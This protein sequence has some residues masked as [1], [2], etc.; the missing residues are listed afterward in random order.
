MNGEEPELRRALEGRS[1]SPSPEFRA[2]LASALGAGRPVA[3]STPRLALAGA[4]ILA[5]AVVG[6][7]LMARQ[8]GG[9]IAP[10]PGSASGPR[11]VATPTPA[12]CTFCPIAMPT[13]A[14]LSAPSDN[15]VW[16]LVQDE[17]LARSTDRGADWERRPLPTWSGQTP[18]LEMSF[19]DDHEG[20]LLAVGDQIGACRSQTFALAHTTD[21]GATWTQL[22]VKG[23]PEE[24]CKDGVSF[25]DSQRGF[26]NVWDE[27]HLPVIYRTTDGGRTW[28]ASAPLP[29]PPGF[30]ITDTGGPL[31]PGTVRAF[32]SIL[33]LPA[34]GQVS[35]APMQYV[36]SSTDGGKTWSYLAGVPVNGALAFK[37]STQWFQLGGS[38]EAI[39][40]TDS[41]K[42]WQDYA[43]DYQQAAGVA[44]SVVFADPLVGYATV[45]GGIARTVDGGHHWV[46]ITTPGTGVTPVGG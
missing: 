14:Q 7:L 26:V 28:T 22:D 36:F 18:P 32:G 24:H 39:E 41:G 4:V 15:V 37:A 13:Y 19:I 1:G 44:P 17:Y 43:S 27:S 12:G 42:T 10:L 3:S 20:W 9:R 35:G 45:R 11:I 8:G 33:L 6:V 29:N 23:I 25:A 46:W 21:A 5:V 40:T 30:K 38:D 34:L 2:R 16:V 31:Q